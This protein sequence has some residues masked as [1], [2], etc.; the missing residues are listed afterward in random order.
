MNE[1]LR[2]GVAGLGAIGLEV[3]RCVGCG[4]VPGL[5]LEAVAARDPAKIGRLLAANDLQ[6][7]IV[8]V[9]E[10]ADHTD[11][12]VE[13]MPASAFAA[14]AEAVFPKGRVFVPVTLGVLLERPDLLAEAERA[15]TTIL[16]PT[17]A[18]VGLD[19]VRAAAEGTIHTVRLV[20]RKPPRGFAG[21]PHVVAQGI[22]LD[23]LR[24]PLLLFRG[25][26][27]AAVKGFPANVNVAVALSLAG[28][29]PDRTEV[30]IWAD[31]AV[32]RNRQTVVLDSDSARIDMTIENLPSA[33]NPRTGRIT[34]LSVIAA[35]RR[36]VAPMTV[37]S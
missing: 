12:I 14:L 22:D 36:L 8:P 9:A 6:A 23:R 35:L 37:G 13:C 19:A 32:D 25:S 11:V 7:R 27:R 2:L 28:I 4:R 33:D 24:E 1:N 31:P 18:L 20:T 5:A 17:G 15:G 16:V 34:P 3:A 26:A 30:E 21:A 10:V 29:G